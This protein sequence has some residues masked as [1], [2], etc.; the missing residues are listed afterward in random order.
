[1]VIGDESGRGRHA[2]HRRANHHHP[3]RRQ[4]RCRG[5]RSSRS[6]RTDNRY[7]RSRG[8]AA[9]DAYAKRPRIKSDL[10][11]CRRRRGRR[12]RAAVPIPSASFLIISPPIAIALRKRNA[13]AARPRSPERA[14]GAGTYMNNILEKNLEPA[15]QRL[16]T[17]RR[18]AALPRVAVPLCGRVANPGT[19]RDKDKSPAW[20]TAL[21]LGSGRGRRPSNNRAAGEVRI[22]SRD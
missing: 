7:S 21:I 4:P 18:V 11:H 9:S 17:R 3:S 19:D 1:M 16:V 5:R 6:S 13:K 2:N 22:R 10:R 20:C 8:R 14:L 12:H 15:G